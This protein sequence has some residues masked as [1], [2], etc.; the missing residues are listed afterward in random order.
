MATRVEMVF[1][2]DDAKALQSMGKFLDKVREVGDEYG[3]T[4]RKSGSALDDMKSKM[5]GML[6]PMAAVGAAIAAIK[7]GWDDARAALSAYNE[8]SQ[9]TGQSANDYQAAFGG[10]LQNLPG[11]SD[12]DKDAIDQR[13]R[14]E[15]SRRSL[16]SGGLVAATKA[17]TSIVSAIP[18]ASREEQFAALQ[19]TMQTLELDPNADAEGVATGL[20]SILAKSGGTLTA[21]Q[22]QNLLRTMQSQGLVADAGK[23]GVLASKAVGVAGD[24]GISLTESMGLATWLTGALTDTEGAESATLLASLASKA[25][26]QTADIEKITGVAVSGN[27]FQ[28]LGQLRE[29]RKT[30]ELTEGELTDVLPVLGARGTG[31]RAVRALLTDEGNAARLAATAALEDPSVLEG[32]SVA[33][34][35]NQMRGLPGGEARMRLLREQAA[36]EAARAGSHSLATTEFTAQAIRE[37]MEYG[38]VKESRRDLAE[39]RFRISRARGASVEEAE[40]EARRQA[41]KGA[42]GSFFSGFGIAAEEANL[43]APSYRMIYDPTGGDRGSGRSAIQRSLGARAEVADGVRAGMEAAAPVLAAE[44]SRARGVPE[45]EGQ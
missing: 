33:I 11:I 28:V 15:V 12:K 30:G 6:G 13:L 5:E 26:T 34:A 25:T 18:N 27:L 20:A 14:D 2:S 42:F 16:G 19:E 23:V 7:L 4:Q 32:D 39:R 38:G 29:A 22:T 43:D 44:L 21:N 35:L 37:D 9:R 1:T 17:L 24:A 10:L 40:A 3:E 45:P 8:E 31:G 36:T 41:S